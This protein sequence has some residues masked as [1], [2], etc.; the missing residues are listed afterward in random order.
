MKVRAL[1][2]AMLLAASAPLSAS[3]VVVDGDGRTVGFYLGVT[4][5]ET[6]QAVSMQG[7]RFGFDRVTGR[8]KSAAEAVGVYFTGTDCTGV[9]F[10]YTN[11]NGPMIGAAYVT[12]FSSIDPPSPIDPPIFYIPQ[13][14][15]P[16][17]QLLPRGSLQY[18]DDGN[19]SQ[20]RCQSLSPS[21]YPPVEGYPLQPNDPDE[22]G[23]PNERF[24]P[25]LRIMSSWFHRD[26]F[27][28]LSGLGLGALDG[29]ASRGSS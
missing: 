8:I 3:P 14:T 12:D 21:E 11:Y 16:I 27:E 19:P 26:G 28:Q 1:L 23:I 7:Y 18:F 10:Q 22:T 2:A 25:P 24:R 15:T 4:S 17:A 29:L 5:D 6:E 13:G 9:A 20:L